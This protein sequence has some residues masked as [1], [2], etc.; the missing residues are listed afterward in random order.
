M[1]NQIGL[2]TTGNE[3]RYGT[4]TSTEQ[5]YFHW[6]DI[7]PDKYKDYVPPLG[8]ERAQERLIQGMLPPDTFLDIIRH[9]TFF[10]EIAKGVEIKILPRY[11]QYRAVGK[12]IKRLKEGKT[13]DER[14]GVVWHTQGS[15]KSLTMVM[16]VRN[17][18]G[19]MGREWICKNY[20]FPCWTLLV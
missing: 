5:Y 19:K 14:S 3:A 8:K 20:I 10:M 18:C 12:I 7:Y 6:K 16:L 11:Q 15:G 13:P 17:G 2:V 9:F 1:V 4:I